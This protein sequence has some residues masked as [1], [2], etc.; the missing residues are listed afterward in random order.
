[1]DN[2]AKIRPLYIGKILTALTDEEHYLT[3]AQ[4]MKILEEQYGIKSHRQTIKADI[5]LLQRFGM[6]IQ[7]IKSTQNRYNLMWQRLNYLSMR[8]NPLNL[9]RPR[10]VW[11]LWRNYLLLQV[12][13]SRQ[14]YAET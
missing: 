1:M 10:K 12:R 5:E 3:T 6:D 14:N 2:D 11:S 8:L 7:E 4:I 9:S 13:T